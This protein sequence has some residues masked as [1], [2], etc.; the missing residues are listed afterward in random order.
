MW[1][2]LPGPKTKTGNGRAC[3]TCGP[4][5]GGPHVS[6]SSAPDTDKKGRASGLGLGV[7]WSRR[8]PPPFLP[9]RD[10]GRRRRASHLGARDVRR[11]QAR[12]EVL[13]LLGLRIWKSGQGGG[14]WRE[15]QRRI[16]L[17][18]GGSGGVSLVGN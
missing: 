1:I 6:W 3:V 7:W 14:I 8:L 9:L 4:C 17:L 16:W 10:R 11:R 18:R 12:E 5:R 13:L 15:E 2:F